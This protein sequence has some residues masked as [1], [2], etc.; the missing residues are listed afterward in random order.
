MSNVI[1]ISF[2]SVV[3]SRSCDWYRYH[4]CVEREE[5]EEENE[6]AFARWISFFLRINIY[7][8]VDVH[9]LFVSFSI[10]N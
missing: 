5:E 10:V 7:S 9:M 6:Q 8:S 4:G 2:K 1:W 3:F